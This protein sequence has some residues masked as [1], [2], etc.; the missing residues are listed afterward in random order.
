[1]SFKTDYKKVAGLGSA[2]EGTSDWLSLR[3]TAIALAPLSL[4]FLYPFASNLG[5]GHEAVLE[6][7][8]RPFHAI[9]AILFFITL[10]RHLRMGLVEVIVDYVHD[11]KTLGVLLIANSLFWRGFVV[12]GFFA[13][14]KIAFSA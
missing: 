7:Y 6:T 4:M 5:A 8:R 11:K 14:A 9:V 3:V 12:A 1:M 13:I 2:K 10:F